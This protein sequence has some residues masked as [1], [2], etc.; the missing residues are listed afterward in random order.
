M[1]DGFADHV[2][3]L[4]AGSFSWMAFPN[5][6]LESAVDLFLIRGCLCRWVFYLPVRELFSGQHTG[7]NFDKYEDIPVEATGHDCPPH[8][9][10][11]CHRQTSPRTFPCVCSVPAL[12]LI[13]AL[14]TNAHSHT[15]ANKQMQSC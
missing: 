3:N 6:V 9:N 11:V 13:I 2:L 1:P 8:V 5:L 10:D 12:V 15:Q 7:I 14:F 4:V